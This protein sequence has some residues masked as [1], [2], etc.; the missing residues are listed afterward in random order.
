MA[1]TTR[2]HAPPR[3]RTVLWIDDEVDMLEPHRLFLAD[4]GFEVHVATN[5]DDAVELLRRQHFDLVLLDEQMPGKRGL[6]AYRELR[7][8]APNLPVVMVTKSEDDTTLRDALG[9]D[10]RD[11]LVKP[12]NPR[13]VLSAVTKILD[14]PA[15]RQQATARAFVER[16]RT[17]ETERTRDLTWRGWIERFDELMHWDIELS[18]AGERGLYES[19]RG[20]YPAMHRDFAVFM[21]R[22]YPRWLRDLEGDRPPLSIDVVGEFLLPALRRS[23]AVLFIVVDCLRLDQWHVLQRSLTSMFEVE[24]SHYFAIL[25][26]ATPYARN[27]L[28]SGLFPGEIAARFP[29]W[30]GSADR[31]DETLNAHERVLLEAHLAELGEK[32]PVRYYKISTPGDSED[33]ERHIAST[34]AA[35]GVLPMDGASRR[36]YTKLP[37]TRSRCDSSRNSGFN[38]PRCCLFCAKRRGDASLCC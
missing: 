25:P 31:D 33:L 14:G 30:W 9:A 5:A 10:I 13:Q 32:A 29:D 36:S 21:Q 37:A 15:L 35:D 4:K 3:R 6:E 18:L 20:M 19:L 34:I 27:A 12:V 7:E 26:T 22:D 24:T 1:S 28:F 23:R 38:V 11:Y 17:L 8:L 2:T 16:F